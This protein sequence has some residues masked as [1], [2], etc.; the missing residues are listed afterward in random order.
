MNLIVGTYNIQ[1]GKSFLESQRQGKEVIDLTQLANAIKQTGVQLCAL[2]EVM[3]GGLPFGN[4]PEA[5]AKSLGYT[6]VFG[7]AIMVGDCEYGNALL[8]AFPVQSIRTV[9]IC[10]VPEQRRG[11]GFYE[12]RVLLSADLAIENRILT[13][14]TCHFGLMPEEQELAVNTIIQEVERIH[15]PLIFAG[16]LN[17]TPDHPNYMRLCTALQDTATGFDGMFQTFPSDKPTEKIDY[18]FISHDCKTERIWV[19]EIVCSDHRPYLAE[20]SF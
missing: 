18:L 8:S 5:L 16:D 6:S 4:Q 15:N 19:P 9:P 17:F 12:D 2:N 13:F 1:H 10:T 3:C 11:K 14:M 7:R 20:I